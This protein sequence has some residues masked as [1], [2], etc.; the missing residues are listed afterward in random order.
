MVQYRL[1][2]GRICQLEDGLF[3]EEVWG[4]DP[5]QHQLWPHLIWPGVVAKYRHFQA[6]G[7]INHRILLAGAVLLWSGVETT[8]PGTEVAAFERLV[9]RHLPSPWG[10]KSKDVRRWAVNRLELPSTKIELG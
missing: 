2:L 4:I 7:D 10:L 6:H 5:G 3:V 9:I 8:D 1:I